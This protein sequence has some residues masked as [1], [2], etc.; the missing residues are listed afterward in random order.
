[1]NFN[2][3]EKYLSKWESSRTRVENKKSLNPPPSM[4]SFLTDPHYWKYPILMC[5]RYTGIDVCWPF[6][7]Y[8]T[9][10]KTLGSGTCPL[11]Q[12]YVQYLHT[13]LY[14]SY[15]HV[16]LTLTNINIYILYTYIIL[17]CHKA[18]FRAEVKIKQMRTNHHLGPSCI[19]T[20][21]KANLDSACIICM[22]HIPL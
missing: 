9:T 19:Y 1:M 21:Q 10:V 7:M 13:Y 16:T 20:T 3:W 6:R 18:I 2:H 15:I 12:I 5:P 4:Y 22:F 11:H 8:L 14:A 17:T